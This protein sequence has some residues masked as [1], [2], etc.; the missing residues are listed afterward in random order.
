MNFWPQSSGKEPQFRRIN[1]GFVAYVLQNGKQHAQC[2]VAFLFFPLAA[3]LLTEVFDTTT[4]CF[5][6]VVNSRNERQ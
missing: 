4:K 1:Q 3:K 5:Y 6:L 2:C